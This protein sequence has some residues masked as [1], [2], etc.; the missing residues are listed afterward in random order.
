MMESWEKE[1][2]AGG[3]RG[4]HWYARRGLDLRWKQRPEVLHG[5]PG[6][7]SD[8]CFPDDTGDK[9]CG[10]RRWAIRAGRMFNPGSPS[11]HSWHGWSHGHF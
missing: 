4:S 10:G 9:V 6:I 2:V 11:D 7:S 3:T 1:S 8:R 5:R